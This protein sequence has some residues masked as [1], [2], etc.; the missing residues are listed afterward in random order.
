VA[1]DTAPQQPRTRPAVHTAPPS[2]NPE[3]AIA[4]LLACRYGDGVYLR[5]DVGGEVLRA[6]IAGGFLSE[7]GFVTRAGRRLLARFQDLRG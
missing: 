4:R 2:A 3:S 1:S 6:A 5:R 7:D